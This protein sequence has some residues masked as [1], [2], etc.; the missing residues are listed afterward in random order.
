MKKS[1]SIIA[2]LITGFIYLIT[3]GSVSADGPGDGFLPLCPPDLFFDTTQD[4]NPSGPTAYL[5][6]MAEKGI[7]F[8]ETPLP[9]HKP[10]SALSD[11]EYRYAYV[12]SNRA[13]IYQSLN[14]AIN[15][16][17]ENIMKVLKEK[18]R[19]KEKREDNDR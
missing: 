2:L 4:C 16:N 6:N 7:T 3:P 8:P 1:Y 11:V 17:K 15:N 13:P 19:K 12:R 10:D 18:T 5:L 14:D 9:S